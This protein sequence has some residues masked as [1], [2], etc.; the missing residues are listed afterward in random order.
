MV[1]TTNQLSTN[2]D[3]PLSQVGAAGDTR[4][5]ASAGTSAVLL[6]LALPAQ[7]RRPRGTNYC[8]Y[9]QFL[10]L[11][12]TV[13]TAVTDRYKRYRLLLSL[14]AVTIVTDRYNC[15]RQL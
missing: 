3:R 10:L 2:N 15:D 11:L 14:P 6:L 8:S 12:P 1:D 7:E 4:R 9:R 13:T 5:D